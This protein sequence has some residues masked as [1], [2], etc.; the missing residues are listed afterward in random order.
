MQMWHRHSNSQG[1]RCH[2]IATPSVV[3]IGYAAVALSMLAP[4]LEAAPQGGFG[5]NYTWRLATAAMSPTPRQEHAM[6]WHP[7]TGQVVMFGGR[8]NSPLS[9]TWTW[10]G[11]NWTQRNPLHSPP[12]R[13][14]H[15]MAT[16][17]QTGH[18][19]LFGGQDG[20]QYFADTWEWDGSDWLLRTPSQSPSARAMHA[21]ASSGND[22]ILFGGAD[23][24]GDLGDTWLWDNTSWIPGI[25]GISP[26]ARR[27]HTLTSGSFLGPHLYGGSTGSD[28]SW[29]W[30]SSGWQQFFP[31]Q[32]PGNRVAHACVTDRSHRNQMV[33]VGGNGQ[34]DVWFNGNAGS[35][36]APLAMAS[37]PAVGSNFAMVYDDF[38]G[39]IVLFG[40]SGGA[41]TTWILGSTPFVQQGIG[42]GCGGAM[43]G[44][45]GPSEFA[46]W[47]MADP[48]L[49]SMASTQVHTLQIG[50]VAFGA[51]AQP[52]PI[53]LS[54]LGGNVPNCLLHTSVDLTIPASVVVQGVY[55]LEIPAVPASITN[56]YIQGFFVGIGN[57]SGSFY[58]SATPA[59]RI[60]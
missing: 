52:S 36:W 59:F 15:R 53:D 17:Y 20:S 57:F 28:E 23:A 34:S 22:I 31:S 9:E 6:G 41:N 44:L 26:S 42:Y 39:N 40:G 18:V 24:S 19:I 54:F 37:I 33:L 38:R 51:Q 1:A 58:L 13:Y 11:G 46:S 49:G 43:G 50:L 45:V 16:T 21:M 10:D 55:Q 48:W 12:A 29:F 4:E 3:F 5:L 14:G 32:N 27:L 47:S 30:G 7:Q 35:D 8:D 56:L 2:H 25:T 60:L